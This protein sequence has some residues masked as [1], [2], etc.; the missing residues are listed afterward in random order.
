VLDS[1]AWLVNPDRELPAFIRGLTGITPA[2]VAA[3]PPFR[4]VYPRFRAFVQDAVVIAHNARFDVAFLAAE[5]RRAN[6][7]T[8]TNRVVDT[9]KL[10]RRWY[11]DAPAHSLEALRDYL[12]LPQGRTHRGLEDAE[13]TAALFLVGL[14]RL[15]PEAT[16][17]DLAQPTP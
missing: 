15:S 6:L 17:S 14:I 4:E 3:A 10:A 2:M 7:G 16:L 5:A 11:P 1:K 12:D 9:L 13:C 8:A